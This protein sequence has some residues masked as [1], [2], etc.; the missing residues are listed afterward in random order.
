[1]GLTKRTTHG[2]P[3]SRTQLSESIS[4]IR[5]T[6]TLPPSGLPFPPSDQMSN[7]SAVFLDHIFLAGS[8]LIFLTSTT[9][10]VVYFTSIHNLPLLHS[11]NK[12]APLIAKCALISSALILSRTCTPW[13]ARNRCTVLAALLFTFYLIPRTG[14]NKSL[15]F[16][17]NC[18]PSGDGGF[19]S[20]FWDYFRLFF[21]GNVFDVAYATLTLPLPLRLLPLTFVLPIV[22]MSFTS[23]N[24]CLAPFLDNPTFAGKIAR[25]TKVLDS[26]TLSGIL[27]WVGVLKTQENNAQRQCEV[28][29]SFFRIVLGG[30][31][32]HMLV[33][34]FQLVSPL[35]FG[36]AKTQQQQ[37]NRKENKQRHQRHG[38]WL[39]R[40]DDCCLF[41]WKN[42]KAAFDY[43][44]PPVFLWFIWL[45][46]VWGI[47]APALAS[48][49]P[50]S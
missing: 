1:M 48:F 11:M 12:V 5:K 33:L 44:M 14:I 40:V 36:N 43:S 18:Q 38:S 16:A 10:H 49:M 29:F 20:G 46:A 30:V 37:Q 28:W 45:S 17:L 7:D 6:Q 15:E 22:A 32:P 13:Y 4:A 19:I 41:V 25:H 24:V 34:L 50:Q 8:L 47:L 3:G 39:Q 27:K 42:S 21:W 9:R 31:I 2:N 26:V 23:E 35:Q